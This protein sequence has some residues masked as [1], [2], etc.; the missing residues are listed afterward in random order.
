MCVVHP[1]GMQW[2]T[3][4]THLDS[5]SVL[6]GA[7]RDKHAL[8]RSN[9]YHSGAANVTHLAGCIGAPDEQQLGGPQVTRQQGGR[10][11]R[12]QAAGDWVSGRYY[13]D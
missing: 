8:Q 10:L 6:R 5:V 13:S 3:E 7:I 2:R 12:R 4:E 11:D 1:G 9:S